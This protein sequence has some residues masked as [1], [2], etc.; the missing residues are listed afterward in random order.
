ME[1]K[2]K[3]GKTCKGM[4]NFIYYSHPIFILL[5]RQFSFMQNKNTMIFVLTVVITSII[6][7]IIV[8]IDN[9]FINKL[10]Y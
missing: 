6:G 8:K 4:A 5:L 7:Y 10:V 9:K 1:G 3:C 2:E